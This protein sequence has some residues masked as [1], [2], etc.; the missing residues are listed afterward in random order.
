MLENEILSIFKK[1]EIKIH[2]NNKIHKIKGIT[3]IC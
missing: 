1:K 2:I 3:E